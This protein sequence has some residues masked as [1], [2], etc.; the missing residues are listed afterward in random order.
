MSKERGAK[1]EK[2][3]TMSQERGAKN[4]KTANEHAGRHFLSADGVGEEER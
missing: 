2:Q 1:N 4:E 3:A